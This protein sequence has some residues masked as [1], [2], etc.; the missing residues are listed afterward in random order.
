MVLHADE[1]GPAVLLGAE[2]HQRELVSPHAGGADVADF[3]A[4]DEGVER[5]HCF[6]DGD[7]GVEAVD[8]EE[9][10]VGG[11]EAGEGVVD[12]GEDG[13]AG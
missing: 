9:V 2:L 4:L 6:G 11:L 12:V 1:F 13:L 10:D 3:A 7:G 8:L 5:G